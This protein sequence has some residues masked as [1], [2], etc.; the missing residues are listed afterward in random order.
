MNRRNFLNTVALGIG[1]VISLTVVSIGNTIPLYNEFDWLPY[2]CGLLFRMENH[3]DK[4][5][6]QSLPIT[7]KTYKTKIISD[8]DVDYTKETITKRISNNITGTEKMRSQLFYTNEILLKYAK[9]QGFT[10][11]YGF[12][13]NEIPSLDPVT[14]KP[15][16]CYYVR[17]LKMPDWKTIN[18]KLQ[19]VNV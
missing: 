12:F 11:L 3:N 17:G 9:E 7:V 15:Y 8:I 5:S 2:P 14:D 16:M 6:I 13:R 4:H 18:G 10:H 1:G 19:I